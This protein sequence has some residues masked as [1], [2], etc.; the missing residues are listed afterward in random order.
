[1]WLCTGAD[2]D[3]WGSLE[4]W[5][6]A[7]GSQVSTSVQ[8]ELGNEETC[9]FL[10]LSLQLKLGCTIQLGSLETLEQGSISC[11]PAVFLPGAG[12]ETVSHLGCA[13]H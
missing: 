10:V 6:A 7:V 1:M 3:C 8:C 11:D 13:P 4:W 12:A 5:G 9:F 2:S